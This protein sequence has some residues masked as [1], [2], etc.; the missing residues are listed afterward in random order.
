MRKSVE[1]SIVGNLHYRQIIVLGGQKIG[2]LTTNSNTAGVGTQKT[3]KWLCEYEEI[4]T[5]NEGL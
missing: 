2:C 3:S 4:A 1:I 5:D